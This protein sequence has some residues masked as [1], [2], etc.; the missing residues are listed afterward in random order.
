MWGRFV[1]A[2]R[3]F[4]AGLGVRFVGDVRAEGMADAFLR[5]SVVGI[6][7]VVWVVVWHR[8]WWNRTYRRVEQSACRTCPVSE[9]AE[10]QEETAPGEG[11]G[12][13]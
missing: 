6:L 2:V 5:A 1:E 4:F 10:V 7:R 12:G 9:G 13:W 11:T 8:R 3:R